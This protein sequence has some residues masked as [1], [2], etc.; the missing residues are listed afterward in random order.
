MMAIVIV[1]GSFGWNGGKVLS[2]IGLGSIQHKLF[3][4]MIEWMEDRLNA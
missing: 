1:Y 3:V 4:C 2:L